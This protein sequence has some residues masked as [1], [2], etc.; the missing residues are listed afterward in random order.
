MEWNAIWQ[1]A[2]IG[3]SASVLGYLKN[4]VTKEKPFELTRASIKVVLG[5][6]FG[7]VAGLTGRSFE[8]IQAWGASA[9]LVV[10]IEQAIK[11]GWKNAL[12][13]AWASI[14]KAFTEA[15]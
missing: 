10:I 2:L 3:L 1:G 9:G 4:G 13:P 14:K 7:V 5:T 6:C 11:G 15:K 12:G 8:S